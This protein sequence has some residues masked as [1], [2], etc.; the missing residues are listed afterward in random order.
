MQETEEMGIKRCE[1]ERAMAMEIV[2]LLERMG[3]TV[4]QGHQILRIAAARLDRYSAVQTTASP[5]YEFRSSS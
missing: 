3:C 1:A 4:E 5:A 2:K